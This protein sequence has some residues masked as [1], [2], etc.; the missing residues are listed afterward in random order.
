[1]RNLFLLA[2]VAFWVLSIAVVARA[3][4][5][6]SAFDPQCYQPTVGDP[7]VIDT[8]YG[9]RDKQYLGGDLFNVGPR[10]GESYGRIMT[11]GFQKDTSNFSSVR[12]GP[13]FNIHK[14]Q[15]EKNMNFTQSNHPIFGHFH[16]PHLTDLLIQNQIYWSDD[17]GNYDESRSSFITLRPQ[18]DSNY[19]SNFGVLTPYVAYLS[20]DSL[21]DIV[22]GCTSSWPKAKSDTGYIIYFKGSKSLPS[23][24]KFIFAD[25]E[26]AAAYLNGNEAR[27]AGAG[28][29]RGSG[30]QDCIAY[31]ALG[32]LFCYKN[33]GAFS[34]QKFSDAI[35]FDT[36]FSRWDNAG[37]KPTVNPWSM[38][39]PLKAFAKAAWDKSLDFFGSVLTTDDKNGAQLFFR[40]GKDFGSRRLFLDSVDFVMHSPRYLDNNWSS[41]LTWGDEIWNCGD[42]TG[43]GNT[44]ICAHG[45]DD[46]DLT[47]FYYFYVL[48]RA[49]DE[50]V[51]MFYGMSNYGTG[52]IDTL[53]ADRDSLQDIINGLVIFTSD[54]DRLLHNWWG[55]GSLQV[56]H[57][58]KQ[59]PVHIS[60]KYSVGPTPTSTAIFTVYPNPIRTHFQADFRLRESGNALLRIFDLLGREVYREIFR[61][62][63]GEQVKRVQ[64]PRLANGVYQ[65]LIERGPEQLRTK[66]VIAE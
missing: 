6:S 22:A 45:S 24:G 21:Q 66:I 65:L 9:S 5:S 64:L 44:V 49:M 55:V 42:M 19:G 51:D 50:K 40:G 33:D 37:L 4:V 60:P 47:N 61:G 13:A 43:T 48:G 63:A 11:D 25:T 29:F 10:Y 30:K 59:I 39:F 15:V 54:N 35:H 56:I 58:S 52:Y 8:I 53:V 18:G 38:G 57:G 20:S 3:Q 62:T 32:D 23:N 46:G 26:L 16:S 31:D 1:M 41:N 2:V 34:L 12:T 36:L 7:G 14:L 28:D 27:G 17:S